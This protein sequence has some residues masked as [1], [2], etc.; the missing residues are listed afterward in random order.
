MMTL[1]KV[2][3]NVLWQVWY[4][5]SCSLLSLN[6]KVIDW[7]PKLAGN[8]PKATHLMPLSLLI[9]YDTAH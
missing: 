1:V 3:T 6:A 9:M 4:G 7:S 8:E 2:L 5:R